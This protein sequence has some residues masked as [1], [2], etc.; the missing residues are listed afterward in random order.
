MFSPNEVFIFLASCFIMIKPKARASFGANVN[1]R[2]TRASS[3]HETSRSAY[4]RATPT[5]I[6]M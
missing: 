5:Y 6:K 3:S 4:G 2:L 1:S